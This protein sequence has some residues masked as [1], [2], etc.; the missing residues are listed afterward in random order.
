MHLLN[1]EEV[2]QYIAE[3]ADLFDECSLENCFTGSAWLT[4]LVTQIGTSSSR[5]VV[6]ESLETGGESTMLLFSPDG[7]KRLRGLGNY[8]S[9]LYTPICSRSP[10]KKREAGALIRQLR[11]ETLIDF[12]PLKEEDAR[13]LATELRR[14]GWY[15]EEYFCFGNWFLRTNGL[16][17]EQ[18]MEQRPSQL[19]NTWSRKRKRFKDEAHLEVLTQDAE[20]GITA[21]QAVYSQSWK[22]PEPYPGFVPGWA[23]ICEARG[24]LRLGVAWVG[25]RPIAAQ[26][27]FFENR[28]AYIFKLAYDE[29][30]A[31]WSAGTVLTAAL[32]Q[33][34]LD[35]D[36]VDEVDF[37]SGDDAYK[38]SWM[39]DRRER[40]GILACN[41]ATARGALRAAYESIGGAAR[42][43][44]Q[45][46]QRG[47][48]ETEAGIATT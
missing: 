37:L 28:K 34:V 47:E 2:L 8:Y 29:E 4:H 45:R 13:N 20:A 3:R 33:H 10:D 1:K 14:N 44:R 46:R 16:S 36:R 43:F 42:R 6:P 15:A 7:K 18:Y 39:S 48:R 24:T 9:S 21:F 35:I 19:R 23:R 26:F 27:W 12:S 41:L 25:K 31:S 38:Q 30:Y 40:V 11:R 17:F 22:R 5:F 32:M